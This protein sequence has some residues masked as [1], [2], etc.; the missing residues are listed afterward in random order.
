MRIYN[1]KNGKLN[2]SDR[3][4]LL[5]LLGKAGY[6]VRLGK[7]KGGNKSNSANIHYVEFWGDD[8]SPER[9]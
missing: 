6:T 1:Q 3:Q 7:S 9:K 2:E 5:N 4:E 8:E